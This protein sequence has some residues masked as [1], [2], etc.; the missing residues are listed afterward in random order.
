M[1]NEHA[2][3]ARMSIEEATVSTIWEIVRIVEVLERTGLCTNQDLYDILRA[4]Q[5]Q[6]SGE[7]EVRSSRAV[8]T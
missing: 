8:R 3:R 2:N 1:S 5:K 7:A 6:N 4:D